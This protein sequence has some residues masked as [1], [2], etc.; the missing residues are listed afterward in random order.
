MKKKKKK[1]PKQ[2]QNQRIFITKNQFK[3]IRALNVCLIDFQ[4]CMKFIPRFK[5]FN[6]Y[7]YETMP[8]WSICIFQEVWRCFAI[9]EKTWCSRNAMRGKK[10][11]FANVFHAIAKFLNSWHGQ[12]SKF[13]WTLSML[14]TNTIGVTTCGVP[15]HAK[16][17]IQS[18]EKK[19]TTAKWHDFTNVN[20][21]PN[22]QDQKNRNQIKRR[23]R[24]KRRS[25]LF[26]F[27]G[28]S[29]QPLVSMKKRAM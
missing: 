10:I 2:Q 15:V 18:G 4:A 3:A 23:H 12:F 9:N 16:K 21:Q 24:Q 5:T 19:F 17:K 11:G 28:S 8:C 29:S 26:K 27:N 1:K 6:H 7:K 14:V 13:T 20:E 22:E 25:T